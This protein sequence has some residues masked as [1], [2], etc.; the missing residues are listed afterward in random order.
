MTAV[1]EWMVS[2]YLISYLFKEKGKSTVLNPKNKNMIEELKSNLLYSL[3]Y[4]Q[5]N[6]NMLE[7][8]IVAFK[9][10]MSW[11]YSIDYEE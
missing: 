7:T 1:N 6:P 11:Q 9:A 5:V 10:G 4:R 8:I 3:R 2:S